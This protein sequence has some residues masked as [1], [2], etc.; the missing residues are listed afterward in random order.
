MYRV[1][2]EIDGERQVIGFVEDVTEMVQVIEADIKANKDDAF[3]YAVED[4]EQ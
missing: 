4:S 2:R 3:Y 1:I